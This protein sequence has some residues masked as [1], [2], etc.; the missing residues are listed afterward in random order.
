MRQLRPTAGTD[1]DLSEPRAE[2]VDWGY[3]GA[4]A[5]LISFGMVMVYSAT[6]V[7]GGPREF[8]K[9][10]IW[11]GIGIPG[12]IFASRVPLSFWR[13]VA[14]LML[15]G[16]IAA[17]VS[18]KFLPESIAPKIKGA[19]RWIF[20]GGYSIQ[21]SEFAKLAFV[22]FAANYLEHRGP[23]MQSLASSHWIPFLGVLGV[24][25][26]LIYKEPDLGTTLVLSG[27][28]FCMLIAAGVN[29]RVLFTGAV[30]AAALILV[31]AWNTDHQRARLEAWWNP[32]ADEYAWEGGY[33]VIQSWVGM[34]RG[35][36]TGVGLGQSVQKLGRL[37][38]STTD[39]I[40]AVVAEELGM[41]RA[42]GVLVLF[43]VLA[44]RGY[45]IA[46]RA[47]DRYSA[48][49]AAGVTSWIAVQSCLNL[50]VVT[51]TVPNTGVPLPFISSG[52]SSTISLMIATG[53]V[54]GI[55]RRRRPGRLS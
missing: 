13:K 24:M 27:T 51:G 17:L 25:A 32:W 50:A 40:F 8:M 5:A 39:F 1:A 31:M 47:P 4:L 55:S 29:W 3:V 36:L 34:A 49:I 54:I 10:G 48:M 16:T 37:P 6:A 2:G 53:I 26:G 46:A 18:L 9:M 21:P 12:M 19:T 11:L 52:G 44:W 33:Q 38:E 43:G 30:A 35:G 42:F 15:V 20:I 14:P 28:A 22:L 45:A 41:F 23:K 7:G